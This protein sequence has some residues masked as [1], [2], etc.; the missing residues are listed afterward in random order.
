[1]KLAPGLPLASAVCICLTACRI[2]YADAA[3]RLVLNLNSHWLFRCGDVPNGQSDSLDE[4]GFQ[5]VCLP[6]ANAI[7]THRNIDM[8]SFRNI[9]WYRRHFSPSAE[10]RGRRFFLEFQGASAVTGAPIRR[11]P[12]IS[13]TA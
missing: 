4:T 10:H 13:R 9:S 11:L 3:P 2:L 6:H 8:R 7:V 5:P 1:M 12:L